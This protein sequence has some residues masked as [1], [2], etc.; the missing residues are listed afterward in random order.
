MDVLPRFKRDTLIDGELDV[1]C[2]LPPIVHST[3]SYTGIRGNR[4][5]QPTMWELIRSS[6]FR[7]TG[8][9]R[10]VRARSFVQYV[11]RRKGL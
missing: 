5:F 3:Q 2:T 6:P 7:E 11:H 10:L 8:A 1:W 9:S 4:M